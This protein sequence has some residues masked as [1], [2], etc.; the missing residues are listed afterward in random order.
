MG[1]C[2]VDGHFVYI[3][4]D[5]WDKYEEIELSKLGVFE[6]ANYNI[7][8]WGDHTRDKIMAAIVKKYEGVYQVNSEFFLDHFV[9][10]CFS[11]KK[12]GENAKPLLDCFCN[13]YSFSSVSEVYGT[14]PPI[15]ENPLA[16]DLDRKQTPYLRFNQ[17]IRTNSGNLLKRIFAKKEYRTI[18]TVIN[19]EEVK[20]IEGN[21]SHF[22]IFT[23]TNCFLFSKKQCAVLPSIEKIS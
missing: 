6:K 14:R 3:P 23:E 20:R 2:V 18:T 5:I 13:L 9:N 16:D 11:G 21:L 19:T 22:E 7:N 8:N 17:Y 12:A 4:K 10:F 15:S 1:Y